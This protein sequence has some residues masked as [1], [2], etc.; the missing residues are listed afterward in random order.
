MRNLLRVIYT[1]LKRKAN[2]LPIKI[3]SNIKEGTMANVNQTAKND[4]AV[5]AIRKEPIQ[6]LPFFSSTDL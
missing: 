6:H 5:S 1:P 3:N 4:N 2:T